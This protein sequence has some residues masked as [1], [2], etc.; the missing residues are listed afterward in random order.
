MAAKTN[1]YEFITN[2]IN[3]LKE[4]YPSLR[5]RTDDYVFS[6]LCFKN[7]FY[8]NPALVLNESDFAE[9]I[10]DGQNDGGADILLSDPNSETSDMVIGQS[11]FYKDISAEVVRNAILKMAQFYKDMKARHYEQFNS[12]VQRRFLNL[13]AEV[14][15]ESK[16]HFVFYTSAP[17]KRINTDKIEKTFREQFTDTSAIEVSILFDN[18]VVEEIYEAEARQPTVERGKILIDEA[19]NFLLYGDDAAIVNVSAR[20]IKDLY[21]A[22]HNNLL[23]RNLRYHIAGS[24]IDGYIKSTIKDEPA[25]FWFKNNGLTITCDDFVI[26]GREVKFRNFSVVNGGQT[27]YLLYKSNLVNDAHPDFY[28]PCKIIKNVGD[29]ENEKSEFSLKIATAANAQKAI[30]NADLKANTLEQRCFAKEMRT[31]GVLY[32]T[33]R[34]DVV[35]AQY[36]APY[37]HTNLLGIGKLC[38]AAIFQE[39]CKSRSKPSSVYLPKYYEPIFNS[40]QMQVAQICKE[41]LYVDHYFKETFLD[42][43]DRDNGNDP[44]ADTRITFAHNARTMCIAFTALAARYHQGN[45]VDQ[46]LNTIFVAANSQADSVTD[47]L[48]KTFRELGDMKTLLPIKLYTDAYNATLDKLFDAI[49]N[50]GVVTYSIERRLNPTLTPSNYLKKDKNYYSI[51]NDHWATLRTEIQKIF[52]DV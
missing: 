24:K 4:K 34:G 13:D 27:T 25:A 32:Q 8:K 2:K 3:E 41:L 29:S 37:L 15:D 26:D 21:A 9:I 14:G 42:N 35:T 38:L 16:I 48:Y 11:K 40:N 52:A 19:N 5:S 46:N 30:T 1:Y 10:V 23:S 51:L 18:D 45:I 49:I 50:A 17:R 28:L 39:P 7:H 6:V 31:V 44:N 12:R 33:K 36:K 22:H 20:S 43:F 47:E